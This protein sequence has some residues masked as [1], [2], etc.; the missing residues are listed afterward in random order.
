[1]HTKYAQ[2]C[3]PARCLQITSNACTH[4]SVLEKIH[5]KMSQYTHEPKH[6]PHLLVLYYSFESTFGRLCVLLFMAEF[7]K[8]PVAGE[9]TAAAGLDEG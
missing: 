9:A 3:K 7:N 1:M 5:R 6:L 4:A 2:V 8:L